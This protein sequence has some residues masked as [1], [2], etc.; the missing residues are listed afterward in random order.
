MSVT[1]N[2]QLHIKNWRLQQKKKK[3]YLHLNSLFTTNYYMEIFS[4]VKPLNIK[5]GSLTTYSTFN[6]ESGSI[7]TL[8]RVILLDNPTL[9][10]KTSNSITCETKESIDCPVNETQLNTN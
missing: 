6:G 3:H 4:K 7:F 1:L 5:L 8:Q 2:K 10:R 9:K